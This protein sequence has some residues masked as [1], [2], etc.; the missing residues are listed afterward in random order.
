[1]IVNCEHQLSGHFGANYLHAKLMRT[2]W[3]CG[4]VSTLRSCITNCQYCKVRRCK[5]ENHLMGDSPKCR[6]NVPKFPFQHTGVD[7]CGPYFVKVG[8]SVVKRWGVLFLCMASRACHI[9]VVPDLTAD[10]FIQCFIRFTARRGLYCR[11]LYS[12]QGTNF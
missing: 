4:G 7:L 1:M 6:V 10:A 3:V 2:F 8:R 9:N 11:F 12:D 5:S